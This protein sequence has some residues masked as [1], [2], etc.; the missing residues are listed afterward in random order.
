LE[1]EV[2]LTAPEGGGFGGPAAEQ[3]LSEAASNMK[4]RRESL[5]G[6]SESGESPWSEVLRKR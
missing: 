5:P 2:V 4:P 6:F 1:L 3:L